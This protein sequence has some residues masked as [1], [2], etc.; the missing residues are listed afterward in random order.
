MKMPEAQVLSILRFLRTVSSSYVV[1]VCP[2]R[3][4]S[5]VI[6]PLPQPL[7]CLLFHRIPP[8][9]GRGRKIRYHHDDE[10]KRDDCLKVRRLFFFPVFFVHDTPLSFARTSART[11]PEVEVKGNGPKQKLGA[12]LSDVC[13]GYVNCCM[14]AAHAARTKARAANVIACPS[15]FTFLTFIFRPPLSMGMRASVACPQV[16]AMHA[17]ANVQI[18]IQ[19]IHVLSMHVNAKTAAPE[20][21]RGSQMWRRATTLWCRRKWRVRPL[22]VLEFRLGQGTAQRVRRHTSV[23][24]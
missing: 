14:P 8:L 9:S 2:L 13:S 21:R 12:A 4:T 23:L 16:F 10:C 24:S 20:W 7:M 17:C 19:Y 5:H 18:I 6:P 3:Q 11:L 1:L 22:H 15:P